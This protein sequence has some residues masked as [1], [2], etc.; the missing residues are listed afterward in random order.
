M[1]G[2]GRWAASPCRQGQAKVVGRPA[3]LAGLEIGEGEVE[4]HPWQVG[5]AGQHGAET[6]GGSLPFAPLKRDRAVQEVE[7]VDVPFAGP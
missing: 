5:I 2:R 4:A 6:L 7:V 3:L 1:P